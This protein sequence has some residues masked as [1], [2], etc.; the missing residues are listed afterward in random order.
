MATLNTTASSYQV[1]QKIL[2][3]LTS[4]SNTEGKDWQ[5]VFSDFVEGHNQIN[6][7]S[8][9]A[10]LGDVVSDTWYYLPSTSVYDET[11]K[12]GDTTLSEGS[13]YIL[14][15]HIGKIKFNNNYQN[16]TVSYTFKREKWVLYNI[17]SSEQENIYV[18]LLPVIKS[19]EDEAW[20]V[21]FLPQAVGDGTSLFNFYI[22]NHGAAFWFG[23][24]QDTEIFI[25]SSKNRFIVVL[26]SDGSYSSLYAGNVLRLGDPFLQPEARVVASS[27][28]VDVSSLNVSSTDLH[29]ARNDYVLSPPNSYISFFDASG[30]F[31]TKNKTCFPNR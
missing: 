3:F 15:R 31:V 25:V 10:D 4:D 28:R 6:T 8:F 12:S 27:H 14:D 24:D 5:I 7:R 13:D 23:K 17:G 1:F 19:S 18:G 16:V 20:L 29:D 26:N 30:N 2:D 11:V 22:P 21:P 9:Q